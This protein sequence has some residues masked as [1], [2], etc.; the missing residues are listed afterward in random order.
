ML[1]LLWSRTIS[2]RPAAL[3]P[4][5]FKR[6]TSLWRETVWNAEAGFMP[7]PDAGCYEIPQC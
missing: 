6:L 2:W 4:L 1:L 5:P 7:G 3:Q